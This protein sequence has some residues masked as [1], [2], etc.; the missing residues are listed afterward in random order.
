MVDSPR[1]YSEAMDDMFQH[2]IP[3]PSNY[4][5]NG[6]YKSSSGGY[7]N[8]GRS[9]WTVRYGDVVIHALLGLQGHCLILYT[10]VSKVL[11]EGSPKL[12]KGVCP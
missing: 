12:G 3:G 10:N 7:L 6:C 8:Y 1:V 11:Q 2:Q 5:E 4:I 9:S